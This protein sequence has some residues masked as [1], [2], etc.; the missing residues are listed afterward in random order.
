VLRA[1]SYKSL[2]KGNW[3]QLSEKTF[4]VR[5]WTERGIEIEKA[6]KVQLCYE[7]DCE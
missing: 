3:I 5:A 6:R 2:K 1:V 7:I 4:Q